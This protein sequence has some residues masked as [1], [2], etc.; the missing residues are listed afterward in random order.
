MQDDLLPG[1][2]RRLGLDPIADDAPVDDHRPMRHAPSHLSVALTLLGLAACS[3]D[4]ATT[5]DGSSGGQTTTTDS[6]AAA[7]MTTGATVTA[8]DTSSGDDAGTVAPTTGEPVTTAGTT[9][10]KEAIC[11][12]GYV[13]PGEPCDDG[14]AEVDDGCNSNCERTG[15]VQ[16]TV[17]FDGGAAKDDSFSGAVVDGTGRIIVVGYENNA[18]IDQRM[19]VAAYDPSGKELWKKLLPGAQGLDAGLTDVAVDAADNIYAVGYE[20]IDADTSQGILRKL[21]KTGKPLWAFE[22]PPQ[23]PGFASLQGVAVT[24]DAVYS[25]GREDLEKGEQMVT[26]RHDAMTGEE[27]WSAVPAVDGVYVAGY[28]VVVRDDEV[29]AVG[30]SQNAS[31]V[32]APL[33]AVYSPA[34]AEQSLDVEDTVGSY[35]AVKLAANGDLVLAGFFSEDGTG[36]DFAVRRI[37]TDHKVLWT[38]KFDGE[39]LADFANGVAV[40]PDDRIAGGGFVARSGQAENT[41]V[42][43]LE[44]GGA[45]IWT[46]SYND[47]D[48]LGDSVHAVVFTPES[49]VAIGTTF[50]IGHGYNGWMRAYAIE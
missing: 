19:L 50:A 6:T 32:P 31:H 20:D 29:I 12:D 30:Q 13:D 40:G 3:T 11:G 45:P 37:D 47:P 16:W 7:T 35:T 48:D 43:R 46:A 8:A 36:F 41:L 17:E 27:V 4:P 28:G 22:A 42:M 34:G 33:I 5:S 23:L 25:T 44:P 9:D 26:R 39:G 49:V 10:V 24:A 14:N 18:D 1:R 2:S 38:E 15:V 21:D